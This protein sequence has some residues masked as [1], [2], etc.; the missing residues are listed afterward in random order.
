MESKPPLTPEV[1]GSRV[2]R[3]HNQAD[4]PL[5][6]CPSRSAKGTQPSSDFQCV[7]L[8]IPG[9]EKSAGKVTAGEVTGL[10][11]EVWLQI[12][13]LPH[14]RQRPQPP[15][16]LP[17]GAAK[18]RDSGDDRTDNRGWV[19][20]PRNDRLCL[21]DKTSEYTGHVRSSLS[22]TAKA[23]PHCRGQVSHVAAGSVTVIFFVDGNGVAFF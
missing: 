2:T 11:P 23:S 7:F 5:S 6:L 13:T 4:L 14:Q 12:R 9:T 10:A 8:T 18:F 3:P 21:G 17:F 20:I 19:S 22:V 15:W 1:V 16:G